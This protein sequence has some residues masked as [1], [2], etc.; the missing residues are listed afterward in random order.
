[1]TQR[2]N[3]LLEWLK[4]SFENRKD[5]ASARKLAAFAIIIS[6]LVAHSSWLKYC[7]MHEDFSLLPTVLG[8]DYGFIAACLALTTYQQVKQKEESKPDA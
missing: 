7:F 3:K 6:V 8:I 1:M 5:G 4:G 2:I